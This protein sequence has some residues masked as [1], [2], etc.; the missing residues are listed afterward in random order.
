[1]WSANKRLLV[2][3]CHIWHH[4]HDITHILSSG[5]NTAWKWSLDWFLTSNY[6]RPLF[7][8]LRFLYPTHIVLYLFFNRLWLFFSLFYFVSQFL[9]EVRG[10]MVLTET[11]EGS[12]LDPKSLKS[13][14]CQGV[15]NHAWSPLH[16]TDYPNLYVLLFGVTQCYDC[17]K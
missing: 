14:I 17:C 11:K 7:N 16:Y 3:W 10:R 13:G 9:A 12:T 8:Q 5:I 15:F 2:P 4:V 6:L 1:M